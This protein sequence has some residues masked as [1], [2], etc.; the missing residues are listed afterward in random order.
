M[1]AKLSDRRHRTHGIMITSILLQVY[2][3]CTEGPHIPNH[4]AAEC[5][6]CTDSV[7]LYPINQL[8]GIL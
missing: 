7:R 4:V 5:G 2:Y 1:V 6:G 3:V 8:Y